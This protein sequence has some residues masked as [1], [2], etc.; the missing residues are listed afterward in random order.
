MA[1]FVPLASVNVAATLVAAA[2]AVAQR[3]IAVMSTI[4]YNPN[5]QPD[6]RGKLITMAEILPAKPTG[7]L[8]ALLQMTWVQEPVL[9]EDHELNMACVVNHETLLAQSRGVPP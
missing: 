4:L 7:V 9:R 1:F 5:K 6:A 2:A 8:T 3:R